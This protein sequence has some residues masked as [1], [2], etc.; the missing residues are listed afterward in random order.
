MTRPTVARCRLA[1]SS[2]TPPPAT[3]YFDFTSHRASRDTS[4]AGPRVR[5]Q[6]PSWRPF[7]EEKG[8]HAHACATHG[9][10]LPFLHCRLSLFPSLIFLHISRSI[11]YSTLPK[12][13]FLLTTRYKP[14][15]SVVAVYT[16]GLLSTTASAASSC[17]PPSALPLFSSS[18][19]FL[20]HDAHLYCGSRRPF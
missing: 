2:E 8:P 9:I 12:R 6:P 1:S 19:Y 14:R 7:V 11:F 16:S 5:C 3:N 17:P 15:L 13:L 20:S 10:S 18:L 4:I